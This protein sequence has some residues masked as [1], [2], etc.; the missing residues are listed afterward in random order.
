MAVKMKLDRVKLEPLAF[1]KWIVMSLVLILWLQTFNIQVLNREVYQAKTK[2]MA[3]SMRNVYADRGQIMDRNG[4]PFADNY[5]DSSVESVSFRKVYD[6]SLKDS[7]EKRDTAF[8]YE[9]KRIFLQGSL[10]SQVIGKLD[11]NGHGN[12]GL[13]RTFDSL[14]SGTEGISV[15]VQDARQREVIGRSV[16]VAKPEPGMNLVLTIDRNMQEIVERALKDGVAEYSA[17]SAS[18]VV[19][20]PYTGEILAMGSYPTFDPNSK[21]KGIGR[22]SKNDIVSMPYEP[23]ST[24]KVITAAAAIENG[25]I[26]LDTVFKN[27]GRCWRW[28]PRSEEICDTHVHGDMDMGEAMVQSSNIVFAKIADKVGAE[29]L[30]RMAR[31]FGFGIK[32]SEIFNGEESGRILQPYELVRD[33]RTLKTMGFGHALLVTPIQMVMAYSAIANGGALMAPKLVKEWR[34][35]NDEVVERMSPDT[36]RQVVSA[37]T[38]AEIRAM[39]NRV[40]NDSGTAQ[41]VVSKKLP[42]MVFGGKTG[43]AEKYNSETHS[44]DGN[45]QVASFIGLAPVENTRYVCLVLVDDPQTRQHHGGNTAGPIFRRIMEGIYFHPQLSPISYNLAQADRVSDCDVDFMGMTVDGAKKLAKEKN[46]KVEFSGKGD[47]VISRRLNTSDT[48][49]VTLSLGEMVASRMPN[50]KGLSLRDAMEIMGNIRVGVEYEGKGRVVSQFPL[51][52]EALRRGTT[53]KLVLKEKG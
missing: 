2:N 9:Y 30:Y 40:V 4:I 39:L 12:M 34:N 53:C 35:A 8:R 26:P 47:R 41:K 36:I 29:K 17:L 3:T 50:L 44:Y 25:S 37:S 51:A 13:E 28:N 43:T 48:A 6:K 42:D 33:D 27:E 1:L 5:Q 38:A 24:F 32:T 49:M 15:G 11:F 52:D 45:H 16:E 10:A 18:A 19:V 46:C 23:G 31:D 7:V 20:D 22:I 14:L 21:T